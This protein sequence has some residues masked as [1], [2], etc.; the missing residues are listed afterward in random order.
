MSL[1][2][3]PNF[4]LCFWAKNWVEMRPRIS[5]SNFCNSADRARH[6]IASSMRT[7]HS[8]LA[9]PRVCVV[10]ASASLVLFQSARSRE[11]C[12]R[13]TLNSSISRGRVS[14]ATA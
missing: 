5:A 3:F 8:R 12:D 6:A 7:R 2:K 10:H 4:N 9:L 11:P 13:V 14:H 1:C